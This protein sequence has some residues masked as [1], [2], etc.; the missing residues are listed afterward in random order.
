M[1]AALGAVVRSPMTPCQR[2]DRQITQLRVLKADLTALL[3][4]WRPALQRGNKAT[5]GVVC[6]RIEAYGTPPKKRN[7]PEKGGEK[8]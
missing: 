3:D 5:P 6:P 2:I 4:G 7:T 1:A 8:E